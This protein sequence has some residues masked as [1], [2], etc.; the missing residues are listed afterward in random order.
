MIGDTQPSAGWI[1]KCLPCV[2]QAKLAAMTGQPEPAINN[3]D[4][5]ANGTGFCSEHVTV[6]PPPPAV[7]GSAVKVPEL[8][9]RAGK[10]GG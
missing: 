8:R 10:R 6:I 2:T 9:K 4:L 1:G 7:V 3:A 5:L